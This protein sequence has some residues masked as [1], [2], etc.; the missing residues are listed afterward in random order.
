[1]QTCRFCVCLYISDI[2]CITITHIYHFFH[3]WKHVFKEKSIL[4]PCKVN[5][6]THK[7]FIV[8]LP[9]I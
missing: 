8:T 4:T 3:I 2:F 6:L 5:D 7:E 9:N 1:M